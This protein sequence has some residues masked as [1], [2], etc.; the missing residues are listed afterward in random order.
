MRLENIKSDIELML[1]EQMLDNLW[2][3]LVGIYPEY[4]SRQQV[5]DCLLSE[6]NQY[7]GIGVQQDLM[8]N[9]FNNW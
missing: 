6:I 5:I 7:V 2:L 1:D 8:G 9:H 4:E 3:S